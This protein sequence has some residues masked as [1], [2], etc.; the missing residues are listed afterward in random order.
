MIDAIYFFLS[1]RKVLIQL[2]Y[3]TKE[4]CS[5]NK[6]LR[7]GNVESDFQGSKKR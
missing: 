6:L 1:N 4:Q 7:S 3:F 2:L 5:G